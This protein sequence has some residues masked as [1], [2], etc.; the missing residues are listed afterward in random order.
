MVGSPPEALVTLFGVQTIPEV[1]AGSILNVDK[2]N[3]AIAELFDQPFCNCLVGHFVSSRNIVYLAGDTPVNSL[4]DR[5]AKIVHIDPVSDLSS[6][7]IQR[8]LFSIHCS[9][10]CLWN[11]L[12]GMLPGSEIICAPENDYRKLVG[13]VPGLGH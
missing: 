9:D 8:N 12:L 4:P 3:S 2:S 6:S 5:T 13:Y 1:V 11:E 10:D 7:T